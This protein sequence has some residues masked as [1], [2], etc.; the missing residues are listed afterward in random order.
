MKEGV[1]LYEVLVLLGIIVIQGQ[2]LI[3][4]PRPRFTNQPWG[5]F[6]NQGNKTT[7]TQKSSYV[8]KWLRFIGLLPRTRF[9]SFS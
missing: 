8:V 4:E 2:P 9:N 5:A 3:C 6:A 7:K 1:L